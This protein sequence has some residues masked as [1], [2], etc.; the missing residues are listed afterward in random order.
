MATVLEK[1]TTEEKLSVLRFLLTEEF[2]ANGIHKD[3]FPAYG[4]KCRLK[5]FTT[6]SRNYLK[7]VRKSQMIKRR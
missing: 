5:R 7:D 6:G 3:M 1:C 4:E 2:N